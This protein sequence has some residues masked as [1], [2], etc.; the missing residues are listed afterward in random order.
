[1]R[2]TAGNVDQFLLSASRVRC[3]L[4]RQPFNLSLVCSIYPAEAAPRQ[5]AV[6]SQLGTP[7]ATAIQ[8][9]TNG[10]ARKG[11]NISHSSFNKIQALRVFKWV[12]LGAFL[13]FGQA[14]GQ[15]FQ[16]EIFFVA[17]AVG[18]ALKDADFVVEAF[19]EAEG[20]FVFRPAV[21]GDAVP[22]T[23]DHCGE[24]F[25]WLEALPAQLSFPVVEKA[26]CPCLRL[27]IPKL[28]EGLTKDVG[29]VQ[30][31]IGVEQ[32]LKA[33]SA[34]SRQVFFV[35]QQDIL[36]P[37]DELALRPRDASIFGFADFIEGFAEMTKDVELIEQNGRLRRVAPRRM[38]KRLPH[39]HDRQTDFIRV[40][41]A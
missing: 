31:L 21:G 24:L 29:R 25:I 36:L 17:Q 18:A 13:Q 32:K 19:D 37:L 28:V 35:R 26:T 27:V 5:L 8:C 7:S 34:F 2:S 33:F 20:D 4:S 10:S 22:V 14:R 12:D 6:T 30:A 11:M 23:L 38:T 3:S 41:L 40:S 9:A 16:S 1:M 15:D 39:V